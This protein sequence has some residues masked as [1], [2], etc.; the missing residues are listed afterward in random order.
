MA[1]KKK[2]TFTRTT[3]SL[4]SELQRQMKACGDGVNWSGIAAAAFAAE[5]AKVKCQK[6]K[7]KMDDVITRLRATAIKEGNE[8]FEG[9]REFGQEWAKQQATAHE[10]K[11]LQ[12]AFER[13][14]GCSGDWLDASGSAYTEADVFVWQIRPDDQGRVGDDF[15]RHEAGLDAD[16][17][18]H[19]IEEFDFIHGFAAGALEVWNEVADKV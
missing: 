4:P 7:P 9:G 17:N 19:L 10:L 1:R 11:R 2:P 3:I 5:V 16:E 8:T 13:S 14:D 12:R 18:R 15:F 6:E